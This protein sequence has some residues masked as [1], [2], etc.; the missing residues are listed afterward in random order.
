M[1]LRIA[2]LGDLPGLVDMALKFANQTDPEGRY[3]NQNKITQVISNLIQDPLG[4]VLIHDDGGMLL[5]VVTTTMFGDTKQATEVAWW[6]EPE[7]RSKGVGKQLLKRF[8]DWAWCQGCRLMS[9]SSIDKS[10]SEYYARNGFVHADSSYTKD[11]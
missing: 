7:A 10:V 6:V 3:T 9:M 2:T 5:G 4:V 1:P 11:I 8:E